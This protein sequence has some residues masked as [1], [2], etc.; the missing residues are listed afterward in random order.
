V[1]CQ[2]QSRRPQARWSE[3]ARRSGGSPI[4]QAAE[5]LGRVGRRV[6]RHNTD[7]AVCGKRLAPG[8]QGRRHTIRPGIRRPGR[9]YGG[10][11]VRLLVP[12]TSG[13]TGTPRARPLPNVGG[14]SLPD[15]GRW[16][17]NERNH[18]AADEQC[19]AG[20]EQVFHTR[21]LPFCRRQRTGLSATM[22]SRR[23]HVPEFARAF[24]PRRIGSEASRRAPRD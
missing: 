2:A 22:R 17:Q 6:V 20:E 7:A 12:R 19:H 23:G 10:Y 16:L 13:L 21:F 9:G 24:R 18:T 8:R 4:Q 1:R 14:R 15:S 3:C 5:F 11:G